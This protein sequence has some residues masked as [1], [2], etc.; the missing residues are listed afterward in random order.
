[1]TYCGPLRLAAADCALLRQID[2]CMHVIRVGLEMGNYS[3]VTNYIAKAEQ[4]P[5]RIYLAG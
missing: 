5:G 4:V 2:M 3:H 1:M